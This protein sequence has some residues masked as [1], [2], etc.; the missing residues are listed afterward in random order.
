[1]IPASTNEKMTAGPASGTA[2]VKTMKMPVPM[3]A[4]TPNIVSW[5]RPME[6]SSSPPS[7]SGF[8]SVTKASTGFFLNRPCP[9]ADPALTPHS[10][11]R[12]PLA[13]LTP[14]KCTSLPLDP[15]HRTRKQGICR[16][17]LGQATTRTFVYADPRRR[18]RAEDNAPPR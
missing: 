1:M 18:K 8:V 4:P 2:S 13:R 9:P 6:R 5:N 3:V 14:S 7:A 15:F 10:Y 16:A 11:R 17:S 12:A